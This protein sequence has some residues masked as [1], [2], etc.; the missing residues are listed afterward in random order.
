MLAHS[1]GIPHLSL[2][3][4]LESE[5]NRMANAGGLAVEH[6]ETMIVDAGVDRDCAH[7]FQ[8]VAQRHHGTMLVE[9]HLFLIAVRD[10]AGSF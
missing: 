5:V 2:G 7:I 4:Q 6:E 3:L 9:H 8:A 10:P 1:R